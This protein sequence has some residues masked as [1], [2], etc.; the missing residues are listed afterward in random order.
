MYGSMNASDFIWILA[1]VCLTVAA[2]P[3]AADA[4]VLARGDRVRVT[5][6]SSIPFVGTVIRHTPDTLT[7]AVKQKI[8]VLPIR[9]VRDL[10]VSRA[11]KRNTLSGMA[12]GA[13]IGGAGLASVGYLTAGDE[14]ECGEDGFL[15]GIGYLDREAMLL[16][17]ASV[18][19]LAGALIGA[20]IGSH[21]YSDQWQR[22]DLGVRTEIGW[23][24]GIP[25]AEPV[26]THRQVRKI[27]R[28]QIPTV[29]KT[30]ICPCRRSTTFVQRW[31]P[32]FEFNALSA[33]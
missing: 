18:G 4:Q 24:G 21:T 7:E 2:C 27:I 30:G 25:A 5:D 32:P 31:S 10:E 22:V 11:Q 6:I 26:T 19:I 16:G 13:V 12:V 3:R 8:R 17:G 28:F 23:S 33:H 29:G 14:P 20:I 9:Y 15:C 1:A